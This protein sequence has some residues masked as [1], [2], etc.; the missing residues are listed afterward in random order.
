MHFIQQLLQTHF[1]DI[2]SIIQKTNFWF[3]ISNLNEIQKQKKEKIIKRLKDISEIRKFDRKHKILHEFI[4]EYINELKKN[5]GANIIIY[6]LPVKDSNNT[7]INNDSIYETIKDI[8]G[9]YNI[10]HDS[11]EK[12]AYIWFYKNESAEYLHKL[13]NDMQIGENIINTD[14]IPHNLVNEEFNWSS[15]IKYMVY[16]KNNTKIIV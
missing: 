8:G 1:N 2:D 4:A 13:I 7:L 5:S 16:S 14:Y 11:Q 12:T 9:I 3:S 15:G 6:N 10:H